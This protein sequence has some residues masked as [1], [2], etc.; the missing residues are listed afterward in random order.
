MTLFQIF[1]VLMTLAAAFSY[2]N[3]RYIRLP[4]ATG[5]MTLGLVL[6]AAVILLGE[7][8]IPLDDWARTL[9]KDARFD[10]TLLHGM[11]SFLLFAGA[12]HVDLSG[13]ARQKWIIVALASVGV[14]LS[15]L[16]VGLGSWW[17]LAWA[18]TPLSLGW[19][20]LFGALI[21]PTDP[22]AVLAILKSAAVP[23]S[24]E[25]TITG[26]SLF[27]DGVAVVVYLIT[28]G[29]AIGGHLPTLPVLAQLLLLEVGGGLVLGWIIGRVAYAMLQAVRSYQVGVIITLAVVSGGYALADAWHLSGPITVVVAGL[30]IG[31]HGRQRTLLNS[32]LRYLDTFWELVDEILNV[33]LFMLI[34]LEVLVLA[35]TWEYLLAGVMLIPTVLLA[36]LI[37]VGLPIGLLRSLHSFSPGTVQILTWGGLRGGVSVALALALPA[38]PERDLLVAVTYSIVLFSILVQGLSVGAVVRRLQ[39]RLAK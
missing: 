7:F 22:I 10:K 11:L 33:I 18:G 24:L 38:G 37:S 31:R 20:F 2:L 39:R 19:C 9:L 3:H 29:S 17:V 23:A 4:T 32:D 14:V 12:L 36:R 30:L 34:G 16:I 35:L 8:G 26:E 1:A 25:I 21:S 5:V 13:L 6:S 27:N 28:L 15:T